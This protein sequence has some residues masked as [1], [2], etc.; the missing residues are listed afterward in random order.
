M[1]WPSNLTNFVKTV[2]ISD[3]LQHFPDMEKNRHVTLL[4]SGSAFSTITFDQLI[5]LE[6]AV[7]TSTVHVC[8]SS[9][10]ALQH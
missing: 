6:L 10:L 3:P 2:S 9:V 4:V 1:W 8:T 5:A 7:L